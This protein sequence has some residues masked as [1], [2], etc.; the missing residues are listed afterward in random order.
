MHVRKEKRSVKGCA[1][2]GGIDAAPIMEVKSPKTNFVSSARK[3]T[4]QSVNQ[5]SP[6]KNIWGMNTKWA[7]LFA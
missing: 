6:P 4:T 2:R 5:S 7:F 3:T 1:F